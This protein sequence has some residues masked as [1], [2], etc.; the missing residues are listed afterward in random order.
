LNK[1]AHH[2]RQVRIAFDGSD[3]T[4][5]SGDMTVWQYGSSQFVWK[6]AGQ[7]G[8]PVRSLPPLRRVVHGDAAGGAIDVPAFSVSV[9]V[10]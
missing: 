6:D 9:I 2:S 8:H 7:A 10:L 3:G 5:P 4:P 1:D